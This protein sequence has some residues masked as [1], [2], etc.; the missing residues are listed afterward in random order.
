[1]ASLNDSLPSEELGRKGPTS[2]WITEDYKPEIPLWPIV[3]FVNSPTY[4]LS[5]HL[6]SILSLLVGKSLSHVRNSADFAPFIAG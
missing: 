2:V 6:V 3:S 4:A 5:K 1:M